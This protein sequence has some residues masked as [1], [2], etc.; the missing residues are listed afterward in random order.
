M[1]TNLWVVHVLVEMCS[2][3][4]GSFL[5]SII[6]GLMV[7]YFCMCPLCAFLVVHNVGFGLGK[8]GYGKEWWFTFVSLVGLENGW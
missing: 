1:D 3:Y 8:N 5:D 2:S 7:G 6:E 4:R